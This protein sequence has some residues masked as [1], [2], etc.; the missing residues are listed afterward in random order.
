MQKTPRTGR[1]Q[2]GVA[3]ANTSCSCASWS[4]CV[5]MDNQKAHFQITALL[6][7]FEQAL[8]CYASKAAS[9]RVQLQKA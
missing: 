3:M 1:D 5:I 2:V 9:L 4:S 7:Q 6:W 8:G